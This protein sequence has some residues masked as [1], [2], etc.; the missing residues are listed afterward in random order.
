[1]QPP[2]IL[3]GQPTQ[4]ISYDQLWEM[5]QQAIA[6]IGA[7]EIQITSHVQRAD[8]NAAV[9]SQNSQSLV[10]SQHISDKQQS[11]TNSHRVTPPSENEP[12]ASRH[13]SPVRTSYS[14]KLKKT[15][16]PP[17]FVS[18][19][20]N[21]NT[22]IN[23]TTT[24]DSETNPVFQTLASGEVK[25]NCP[26]INSYREVT[27]KLLE[28]QKNKRH[29]L[30]GIGFHTYRC[31]NEKP[32]QV[33]IRGL[34]PSTNID[35]IKQEL[36]LTGHEARDII[37]III[38]RKIPIKTA[39]GAEKKYKAV[40]TP[41]PLFY[42][43]LSPKENNKCIYETTH[44][45]HTKV[46]IEAPRKKKE[47]PQCKT[48][49]QF[50]HTRNL[51]A[52]SPKCVK[53]GENH[54]T[55]MCKKSKEAPCKCANCGGEHTANWKGCPA[56]QAKV[57]AAS[58]PKITAQQRVQQKAAATAQP[59][60]NETAFVA[61]DKTTQRKTKSAADSQPSSSK[62]KEPTLEDIWNLLRNVSDSMSEIN[63]RVTKL[64]NQSKQ[65][66]TR[67]KKKTQK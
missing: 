10:A 18:G 16:I 58:K 22:L 67:S 59:T 9:A 57:T 40:Q 21:I 5:Y 46:K 2:T 47:I 55:S 1:M 34:H 51:C 48:C 50:G 7:L 15:A 45:L 35:E 6:R 43:N 54:L 60:S 11:T 25:I 23:C 66:K 19:V 17:I 20:Q 26:D 12:A 56:Y 29:D 36:S 30:Y 24:L 62:A 65:S 13:N 49:Q 41:L 3:V 39:N 27:T 63:T 38:K 14:D 44:L 61:N 8:Y 52:K 42:V 31:K 28:F 64:E 37:N 4:Q 33:V 53:C 32:Y